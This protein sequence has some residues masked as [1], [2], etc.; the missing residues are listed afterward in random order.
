MALCHFW[1][2][3][4]SN[5]QNKK[6]SLKFSKNGSS[7]HGFTWV[8]TATNTEIAKWIVLLKMLVKNR[9][10]FTK[11]SKYELTNINRQMGF[12]IDVSTT[13][14]EWSALKSLF[15]Q[16]YTHFIN[17]GCQWCYNVCKQSLLL[18]HAVAGCEG[19][20]G[21]GILSRGPPLSLLFD[22]CFLQQARVRELDVLT[23]LGDSLCLIVCGSFH[24]VSLFSPFSGC[25]GFIYALSSFIIFKLVHSNTT[26]SVFTFMHSSK[27]RRGQ[28][29]PAPTSAAHQTLHCMVH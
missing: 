14:G 7:N 10:M 12:F 27:Y 25:F 1:Q 8:Y 2:V 6:C 22:I 9:E 21:L 17:R 5:S 16:S 24:F 18:R 20:F 26:P 13:H 19:S 23:L 15:S 3:Q 28:S 11:S 4:T 29:E